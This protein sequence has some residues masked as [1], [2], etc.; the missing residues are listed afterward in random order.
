MASPLASPWNRGLRQREMETFKKINIF[1]QSFSSP[2]VLDAIV[3]VGL[4]QQ[5]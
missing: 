2:D 1:T 3:P 4:K 5:N